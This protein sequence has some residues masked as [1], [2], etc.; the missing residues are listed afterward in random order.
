MEI[1]LPG[2][3]RVEREMRSTRFVLP[4][5]ELKG[6]RGLG[7]GVLVFGLFITGFMVL[8]MWGP[9]HSG[10]HSKGGV[11][12]FELIFGLMGL[13]GLAVGLGLLLAGLGIVT[14]CLRSEI[15]VDRDCLRASERLGPLGWTRRRRRRDISRL[16]VSD[17]SI[18]GG[19]SRRPDA[20]LANLCA[21]GVGMKPMLLAVGYSPETV[22]AV[23]AQL[24]QALGV[25]TQTPPEGGEEQGEVEAEA[26]L[27]VSSPAGTDIRLAAVPGGV[28]I[29]VPPAGLW[30]GSYGLFAFSLVWNAGMAVFIAVFATATA[31]DPAPAGVFLILLGFAAVGIGMLL[32][33]VNV[34][35]RRVMIGVVGGTLLI[36]RITPFGT[37]DRRFGAGDVAAVRLG[38]SGIEVN[39][40]RLSELQIHPKQG[41]KVGVLSGRSDEEIAWLAC[42]LRKALGVPANA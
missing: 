25:E 15:V 6:I 36:R 33:A 23:A 28:S 11:R 27:P 29:A 41:R 40:R 5:R 26:D 13:P 30:R 35:R 42:E 39:D 1:Q 20:V 12:W 34:G 37:K 17:G 8:W 16:A 2:G 3:V 31:R 19:N 21:E 14:N 24:S 38:P 7:V 4:P 9:L 22:R 10:L 18:T 32:A